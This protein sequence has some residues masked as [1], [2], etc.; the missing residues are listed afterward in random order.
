MSDEIWYKPEWL[1]RAHGGVGVVVEPDTDSIRWQDLYPMMMKTADRVPH[2]ADW[3]F[4]LRYH[5]Y[6]TLART[7]EY[8][9]LRSRHGADATWWFPEITSSLSR[10][11]KG[12]ILDGEV[13]VLDDRG[14]SH[15]GPLQA[16]ARRRRWYPDAPPVTFCVFDVLALGGQDL[17]ARPLEHRQDALSWLLARPETGLLRVELDSRGEWLYQQA[18]AR[19]FDGIVARRLGSPYRDGVRSPDWVEVRPA[20]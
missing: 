8:P 17:R 5:G 7:G 15:Y 9:R 10:L 13:C 20:M 3:R 19:G 6:R 12:C 14:S 2:G 16:R 4:Q 1:L 18:L 11:P